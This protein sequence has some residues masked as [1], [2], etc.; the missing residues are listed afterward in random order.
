MLPLDAN[1][2]QGGGVRGGG[3]WGGRTT[4]TSDRRENY[5]RVHSLTNTIKGAEKARVLAL[6]DAISQT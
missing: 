1:A 5:V 4:A 2:V 6:T 3:G